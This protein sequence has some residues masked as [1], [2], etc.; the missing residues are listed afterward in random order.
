MTAGIEQARIRLGSLVHAPALRELSEV[1]RTYLLAMA[2]DSRPSR[3]SE[4]ARRMGKSDQYASVYRARLIAAGMIEPAGHGSVR[5]A[6]PYL[7]DYLIDHAA[8]HELTN[9]S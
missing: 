8:H 6:I 2:Q 5:F 3:S 1:D 4:V 9:R 7:R